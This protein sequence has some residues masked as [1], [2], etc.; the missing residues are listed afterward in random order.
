MSLETVSKRWLLALGA[1]LLVGC[2]AAKPYEPVQPPPGGVRYPRTL[3]QGHVFY[4]VDDRWYVQRQGQWFAYRPPP[5][6]LNNY[7]WR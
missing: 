2:A 4:W 5:Q 7:M 6:P 3:H 1:G